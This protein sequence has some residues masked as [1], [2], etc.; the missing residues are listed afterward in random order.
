MLV[1]NPIS[2]ASK[3]KDNLIAIT[4]TS[5]NHIIPIVQQNAIAPAH[6]LIKKLDFRLFPYGLKWSF[7]SCK[8]LS[9]AR[10]PFFARFQLIVFNTL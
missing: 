1:Q 9:D 5:H 3:L 7:S 2:K 10:T 4:V 6:K 8:P